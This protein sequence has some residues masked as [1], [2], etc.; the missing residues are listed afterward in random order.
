MA[1]LNQI[2]L[3]NGQVYSF[4]QLGSGAPLLFIH[5]PAIGHVNFFAQHALAD[6][7]QLIIPDLPGHGDSSPIPEPFSLSAI[8][9]QLC[10]LLARITDQKAI[11]C[12]YSQGGPLALECLL[13]SPNLFAGGILVS[14]FSEVNELFLH[15]RFYMAE[16]LTAMHGIGL[17]ASSI[18]SSH[19]DD[20]VIQK[21]WI[22]HMENTDSSTLLQ[23]Y[24]AGHAEN[25]TARLSEIS[26]PLLLLCGQEDQ[27]M[28]P[29]AQLI[30]K[31]A[32]NART[33][34]L[35]GV[36]HQIVT[37]VPDRFHEEVR[38]FAASLSLDLQ[39]SAVPVP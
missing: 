7:F 14:G 11:V 9:G 10:E 19:V 28:H 2:T 13:A 18:A 16:A 1:R 15:T 21:Q 34:I 4:Q 27:R 38:C 24:R 35:S 8:A 23:L 30:E 6:H 12:G 32:P 33:V 25:C 5:A 29:Y 26:S 20:P 17:L 3:A 39:R 31:H 36:N 22:S 37:K